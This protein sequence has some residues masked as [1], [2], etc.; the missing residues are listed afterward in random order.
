MSSIIPISLN[1][2]NHWGDKTPPFE[3]FAENPPFTGIAPSTYTGISLGQLREI[4][5]ENDDENKVLQ[6]DGEYV[7]VGNIVPNKMS[8]M[9]TVDGAGPLE[10]ITL[11]DA[12]GNNNFEILYTERRMEEMDLWNWEVQKISLRRSDLGLDD[13]QYLTQIVLLVQLE[14]PQVEVFANL[15]GDDRLFRIGA[16]ILNDNDLVK[17]ET[18]T[19]VLPIKV[20]ENFNWQDD[21]TFTYRTSGKFR[22]KLCGIIV[23]NVLGACQVVDDDDDTGGDEVTGIC[24]TYSLDGNPVISATGEATGTGNTGVGTP[25]T[26]GDGPTIIPPPP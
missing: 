19:Y 12:P 24:C 16:N 2:Y 8:G 13:C 11:T 1:R 5:F 9:Y 3:R 21:L 23:R 20:S 17:A 4:E 26:S 15:A 25:G 22:I 7:L 6:I 18:N 10:F 14:S